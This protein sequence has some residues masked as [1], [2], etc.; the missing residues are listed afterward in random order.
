MKI[1][2]LE[3]NQRSIQHDADKYKSRLFDVQEDVKMLKKQ[4]KELEAELADKMQIIQELH[5]RASQQ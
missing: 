1:K 2:Q 3:I 4:K 5:Q